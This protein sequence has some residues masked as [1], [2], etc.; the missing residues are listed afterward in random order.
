MNVVLKKVEA[1][2]I[3][4]IFLFSA[5]YFFTFS[6]NRELD[7]LNHVIKTAKHDTSISSAYVT[8][9][10]ILYLS[11]IDT[12]LPLCNKAMA[13][14]DA[15]LKKKLDAKERAS[16]L[17]SKLGAINNLGYY[18]MN[19]GNTLNA[20][21][22]YKK[23]LTIA[24]KIGNKVGIATALSNTGQIY[25]ALGNIPLALEYYNKSLSIYELQDVPTNKALVLNNI[26]VIYSDLGNTEKAIEFYYRGLFIYQKMGSE[27]GV[28][29]LLNNIGY[30]CVLKKEYTKALY[31]QLKSLAICEKNKDKAGTAKTLNHIGSIY[32]SQ[33][34]YSQAQ[35]YYFKGL[36]L[37][38]ELKYPKETAVT[39]YS[40]GYAYFEQGKIEEALVYGLR[41]MTIARKLGY[42][43]AIRLSAGLLKLVYK[44]RGNYKKAL[45]MT[46]LFV[47]MKDSLNNE[48]TKKVALK[49]Q[50]QY[51]YSK[52]EI[53]LGARSKVEKEKAEVLAKEE[54]ERQYMVGIFVVLVF[55]IV[56]LTLTGINRKRKLDAIQAQY[57]LNE[58]KSYLR[59]VMRE[60]DGK[61]QKEKRRAVSE[62]R[63]KISRDM[64]DELSGALAGLKYYI[65]DLRLKETNEKSKHLLEDIESEVSSVYTQAREY[66]HSLSEGLE[67]VSGNI[68]LFLQNLSGSFFIRYGI[69]VVL[70]LKMD[71]IES[72]IDAVQ[73]DQLI[74][75]MKEAI[76]NVIKHSGAS[77]L[78]IGIWFSGGF[79]YFNIIDNGKGFDIRT[80]KK[81]LGVLSMQLRMD[82]IKGNVSITSSPTGTTIDGSF[83]VLED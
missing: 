24:E 19:K 22:C 26:A 55:A 81:G 68:K 40:I 10:E 28:A 30:E 29:S 8:L 6:Q 53:E 70:N 47:K 2:R 64:H 71:D 33:G 42:P 41:S 23:S 63:G 34:N 80:I 25:Y 46:E 58:E 11:N 78:T 15:N 50:F 57:S 61:I 48:V 56:T 44:K 77:Q 83:P 67:K 4:F 49:N 7:S 38:E 14:A 12:L 3:G 65:N 62:L 66:M 45:E 82:E 17:N 35:K 59:K 76:T 31:Y 16:F 32:D 1:K 13:I 73:Q 21:D 20:L 79:C 36:A 60:R 27:E 69:K 54:K 51:E 74:L 75:V 5:F 72:K 9:T 37:M 39:L 43:N 52:K 18:Y